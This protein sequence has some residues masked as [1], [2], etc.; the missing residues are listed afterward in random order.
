MINE[1]LQEWRIHVEDEEIVKEEIDRELK[2][3][4]LEEKIG[5]REEH[6]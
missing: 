2:K 1:W 5:Q 4:V 6:I 3:E